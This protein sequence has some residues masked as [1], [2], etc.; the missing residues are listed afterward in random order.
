MH[1]CDRSSNATLSNLV[2]KLYKNIARSR[3]FCRI[4]KRSIHK[5]K[6]EALIVDIAVPAD[7]RIAEKE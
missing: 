2:Y 3:L 7:T 5:E 1:N 4:A 6:K